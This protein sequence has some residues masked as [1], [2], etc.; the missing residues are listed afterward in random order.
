KVLDFP[1]EGQEHPLLTHPVIMTLIA[2]CVESQDRNVGNAAM[3]QKSKSSSSLHSKKSI[4]QPLTS[5]A[6]HHASQAVGALFLWILAQLRY[7]RALQA[8]RRA[9]PSSSCVSSEETSPKHISEKGQAQQL[10]AAAVSVALQRSA[11]AARASAAAAQADLTAAE[12]E[13][14]A[15]QELAAVADTKSEPQPSVSDESQDEEQRLQQLRLR[16]QRLKLQP[17]HPRTES[18]CSS[19]LARNVHWLWRQD[20]S[21]R[22]P[23]ASDCQPGLGTAV[24]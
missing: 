15:L 7:A 17:S 16:L 18:P 23:G 3:M 6:A 4:F 8:T 20:T 2:S 12:S 14:S 9:D 19:L 5:E 11:V 22:W 10:V 13:V 24:V 21:G 1:P